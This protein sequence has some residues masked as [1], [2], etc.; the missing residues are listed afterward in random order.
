MESGQTLGAKLFVTW[1]L[2]GVA[3]IVF[4][5]YETDKRQT[6]YTWRLITVWLGALIVGGLYIYRMVH[7]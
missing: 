4:S 3:I 6:K 2:F 5:F 7:P 1:A